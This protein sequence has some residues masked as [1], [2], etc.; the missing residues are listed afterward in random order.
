ME[1]NQKLEENKRKMIGTCKALG[2]NAEV[3]GDEVK[4]NLRGNHGKG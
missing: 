1:N 2:G 4:C 3:S